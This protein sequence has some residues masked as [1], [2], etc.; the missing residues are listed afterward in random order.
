MKKARAR[1]GSKSHQLQ[2][3]NA[4]VPPVIIISVNA[5]NSFINARLLHGSRIL[6]G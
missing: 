2:V 1:P 3:R 6:T 4:F 5:A